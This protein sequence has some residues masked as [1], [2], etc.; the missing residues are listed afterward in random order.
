M[1]DAL[2]RLGEYLVS[3]ALVRLSAP[4]VRALTEDRWQFFEGPPVE[5][6]G[7]TFVREQIF[8]PIFTKVRRQAAH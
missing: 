4:P 2:F 5:S 8:D 3:C 7:R 1:R 6:E